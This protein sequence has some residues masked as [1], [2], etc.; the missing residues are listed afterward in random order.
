VT[1]QLANGWLVVPFAG[2]EMARVEIGT[3]RHRADIWRPAYLDFHD[4][5]RVAKVRP[6]AAT[7]QPVQV[8]TRINGVVAHAGHVTI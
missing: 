8:W 2:P 4:G 7:G 5:Q 1:T 3:G 6:P